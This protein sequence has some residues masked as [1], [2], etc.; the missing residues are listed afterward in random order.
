MREKLRNFQKELRIHGGQ[1]FLRWLSWH[2][3]GWLFHFDHT[4]NWLSVGTVMKPPFD[5]NLLFRMATEADAEM[6]R[7]LSVSPEEFRRRLHLDDK[8]AIAMRNDEVRSMCWAAIGKLWIKTSGSVLDTGNEGLYVYN[9][10]TLPDERGK[11]L[12]KG[13]YKVLFDY[14]YPQGRTKVHSA[15]S[16]FNHVSQVVNRKVGAVSVGETVRVRLF[17]LNICYYKRWPYPIRRL[18][19]FVRRPAADARGV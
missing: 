18:Q 9:G 11:G 15:I 3:P 5:D 7:Q 13:C 4:T 6:M 2:T 19:F 10:Y 16:A 1:H 12:L 17:G 14:Y 8:C